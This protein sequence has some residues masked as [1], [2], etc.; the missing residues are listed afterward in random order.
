MLRRHRHKGGDG[1]DSA[2]H[3]WL[4]GPAHPAH[5]A[6]TLRAIRALAADPSYARYYADFRRDMV[7]GD[8]IDYT[9]CIDT[10]QALAAQLRK[11]NQ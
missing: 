7:Y 11:G 8:R 2:A 3:P 9:T 10:L 5:G 1:M 6:E 4:P